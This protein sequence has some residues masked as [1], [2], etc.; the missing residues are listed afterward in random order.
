MKLAYNGSNTTHHPLFGSVE[1][2]KK[3]TANGLRRNGLNVTKIHCVNSGAA[4][5]AWSFSWYSQ[6]FKKN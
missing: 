6:P 2:G 4:C 3:P 5:H 1:S